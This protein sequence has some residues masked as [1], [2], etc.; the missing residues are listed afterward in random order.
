MNKT[1]FIERFSELFPL[2]V[3]Y[4]KEHFLFLPAYCSHLYNYGMIN[5]RLQEIILIRDKL[6][7]IDP[8]M[9]K[10]M[11]VA[12]FDFDCDYDDWKIRFFNIDHGDLQEIDLIQ[13]YYDILELEHSPHR[14]Q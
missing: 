9:L 12:A 6:E 1:Q 11:S 10:S 14:R 3:K 5:E 7:P 8:Y 13:S 4:W 2:A